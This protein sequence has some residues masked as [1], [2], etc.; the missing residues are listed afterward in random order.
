MAVKMVGASH[1]LYFKEKM[2]LPEL[3]A[4]RITRAACSPAIFANVGGSVLNSLYQARPCNAHN[5][6]VRDLVQN[7]TH[8]GVGGVH[9]HWSGQWR[10]APLCQ[11]AHPLLFGSSSQTNPSWLVTA[12]L[13][14]VSTT[15]VDISRGW[16]ITSA[17]TLPFVRIRDFSVARSSSRFY[18]GINLVLNIFAYP[19][20]YPDS[21]DMASEHSLVKQGYKATTHHHD[22]PA[23]ELRIRQ[24]WSS[25]YTSPLRV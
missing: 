6:A 23:L 2:Y 15:Y 12:Y 5:Y 17:Y 18:I 4:R 14:T 22:P 3:T 7:P 9:D 16:H 25:T 1:L 20:I 13:G 24:L 10:C 21:I 19:S 11:D 8:V